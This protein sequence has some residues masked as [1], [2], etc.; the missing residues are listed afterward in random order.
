[1]PAE[2]KDRGNWRVLEQ[3][4]SQMAPGDLRMQLETVAAETVAQEEEHYTWGGRRG[5]RW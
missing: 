5:R 3:L 2:A 1:M 4:A